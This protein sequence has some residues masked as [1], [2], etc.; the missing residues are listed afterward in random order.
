[1][2]YR[3]VLLYQIVKVGQPLYLFRREVLDR[4]LRGDAQRS[5]SSHDFGKDI[6]PRM[7]EDGLSAHGVALETAYLFPHPGL[8]TLAKL[9]HV[10][11]MA[12]RILHGGFDGLIGFSA[13]AA[14]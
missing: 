1:M 12:R 11:A 3:I 10:A 13:N 8:G 14:V 6:I 5:S 7:I 2:Q 4:L 9:Y